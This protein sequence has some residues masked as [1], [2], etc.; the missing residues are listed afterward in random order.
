M[1]KYKLRHL[2]ISPQSRIWLSR[3]NI[4]DMSY[5]KIWRRRGVESLMN[6]SRNAHARG[7]LNEG[8]PISMRGQWKEIT[9]STNLFRTRVPFVPTCRDLHSQRSVVRNMRMLY[10][11]DEMCEFNFSVLQAHKYA[12]RAAPSSRSDLCAITHLLERRRIPLT[13]LGQRFRYC[14]DE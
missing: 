12:S 7:C 9:G 5:I 10:K 11:A 3:L 8:N 2:H 6:L 13:V 14:L 4:E 1:N